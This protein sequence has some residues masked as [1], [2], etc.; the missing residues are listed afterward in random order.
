[1]RDCKNAKNPGKIDYSQKCFLKTL[2][3]VKTWF[4]KMRFFQ[5]IVKIARSFV[6]DLKLTVNYLY[7]VI[8]YILKSFTRLF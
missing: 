6:N 2:E 3:I 5:E 8:S 1:M 4:G 7:S